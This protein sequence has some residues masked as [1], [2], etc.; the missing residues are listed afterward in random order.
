MARY[1]LKEPFRAEQARRRLEQLIKKGALTDLTEVTKRSLSQ[2]NYLHLILSY[3]AL[4]LGYS[5][6]YVKL[7]IF[8][9]TWN[10]DIF[11]TT[12]VSNKTGEQYTDIR[13]T[14]D[15]NKEEM[16]KAIDTFI[17]KA[18]LEANIRLPIPSDLLYEDE[19]TKIAL[20]VAA[21]EK[22]L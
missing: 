18:S 1:N 8:K 20:E 13:S 2:N 10:K 14:A 11:V 4:E 22:Y 21:N 3:F 19:M 15:L 7:R 12:K 6:N 17:T 5:L 9:C 16:S